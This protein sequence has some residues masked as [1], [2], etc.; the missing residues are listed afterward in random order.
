[1]NKEEEF[2]YEDA[3]LGLIIMS[4]LSDIQS[5]ALTQSEINH[6]VDFIKFLVL[7]H[8]KLPLN[9]DVN[10]TALYGEFKAFRMKRASEIFEVFEEAKTRFGE[11]LKKLL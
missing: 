1:M 9:T 5:G 11:T 3:S 6:K 10:S 7:K 2:L 4:H 8:K